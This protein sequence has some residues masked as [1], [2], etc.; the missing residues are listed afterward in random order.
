MN[1]RF[2]LFTAILAVVLLLVCLPA[3]KAQMPKDT[4]PK[5]APGE[6]SAIADTVLGQAE[7][8]SHQ[9]EQARIDL[10]LPEGWEYALEKGNNKNDFCI[11]FRPKG[12]E[13]KLCLWYYE[14]F[15]VCGTGL[16]QKKITLGNYEAY[17]GTYAGSPL[18]DYISF[19]N[20]SDTGFFVV[21]NEGAEAWWDTYKNEAMQI[22]ST[23]YLEPKEASR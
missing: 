22:L 7:K 13:G 19:F 8:V 18:W 21:M 4:V 3:C 1:K 11:C 6:T 20:D 5:Q 2:A 12:K 15:G 9:N 17:Q 23:L 16:S 10:F 14:V